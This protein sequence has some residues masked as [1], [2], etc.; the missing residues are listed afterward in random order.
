MSDFVAWNNFKAMVDYFNYIL[1]NQVQDIISIQTIPSETHPIS[2]LIPKRARSRLR[3][4]TEVHIRIPDDE[5]LDEP[6]VS[7]GPIR[8]PH[9]RNREHQEDVIL[10]KDLRASKKKLPITV[11]P[12][13][14]EILFFDD[15]FLLSQ[16]L[17][18]KR[19]KKHNP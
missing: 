19:V 14:S 3:K 2:N 6:V 12:P 13:S 10:E 7:P 4:T 15:D 5:V 17:H 16:V 1:S 11:A 18:G 8:T 9:T